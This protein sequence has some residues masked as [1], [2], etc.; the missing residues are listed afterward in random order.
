MVIGK[1]GLSANGNPPIPEIAEEC[2]RITET[3]ERKKWTGADLVGGEKGDL[4]AKAAEPKQSSGCRENRI[5]LESPDCFARSG[6]R[7]DAGKNDQIC[8]AHSCNWFPK[9]AARQ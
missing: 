7:F 1:D 2:I 6:C 5:L 8:A 3:A 9:P 4:F